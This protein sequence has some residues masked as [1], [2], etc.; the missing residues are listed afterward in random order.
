MASQSPGIKNIPFTFNVSTISHCLLQEN[1]KNQFMTLSL[2][3]PKNQ[4][5]YKTEK[6]KNRS[7]FN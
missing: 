2:K 5:N 6:P 7:K 3:R 1:L 4:E